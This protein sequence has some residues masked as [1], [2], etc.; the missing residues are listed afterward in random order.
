MTC[1]GESQVICMFFCHQLFAADPVA[2]NTLANLERQHTVQH[3]QQLSQPSRTR[4]QQAAEAGQLNSNIVGV[5]HLSA[6]EIK[7][8]VWWLTQSQGRPTTT[9]VPN[10]HIRSRRC[11]IQGAWTSS[12]FATQ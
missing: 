10:K 5:K 1:E 9:R 3:E 8:I 12:T 2:K 4:Q 7:H 6:A 11:S